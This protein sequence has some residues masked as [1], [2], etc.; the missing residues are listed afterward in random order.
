ML[1]AV[2]FFLRSH[3]G[4]VDGLRRMPVPTVRFNAEEKLSLENMNLL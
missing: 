3:E 4:D 1:A 2:P